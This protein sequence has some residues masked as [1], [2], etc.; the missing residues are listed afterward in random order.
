MQPCDATM[1]C[2]RRNRLPDSEFSSI[3]QLVKSSKNTVGEIVQKEVDFLC[4]WK[5]ITSVLLANLFFWKKIIFIG[6]IS[7]LHFRDTWHP[8]VG[9]F[10]QARSAQPFRKIAQSNHGNESYAG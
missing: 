2:T 4:V 1:Q 3:L 6:K 10:F 7:R 8:R 9:L 5:R